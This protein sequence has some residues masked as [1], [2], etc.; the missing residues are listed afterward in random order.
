MISL[1][2]TSHPLLEFTNTKG[3]ASTLPSPAHTAGLAS[4][5]RLSRAIDDIDLR[6]TAPRAQTAG[7]LNGGYTA[8]Y[9]AKGTELKKIWQ[10][11]L[12][13]CHRSDPE[14]CG[15]VS[16]NVFIAALEKSDLERAMTPEAM[17]KL[18]DT[19]TLSNGLVNYL[20]LFRSYLNDISGTPQSLSKSQSALTLFKSTDLAKSNELKPIHP[21]H[22]W[23]YG[24]ERTKHP[25]H[26]YWQQAN[27]MPRLETVKPP[28]STATIPPPN[29]KGAH[30]LT[31]SEKEAL[32]SQFHPKV[33]DLC[34][35]CYKLLA[36]IWR[37]L[38]NQFKKDQIASQRGSI[39]TPHFLSILETNGIMLTKGELATIVR[40]FRGLGMQDVVKYDEFLRVCMLVKDRVM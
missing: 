14:R 9:N 38:R 6:N 18:A 31:V 15:Q 29:E 32:L 36:P 3:L 16:R 35:R 21:V 12:R 24:Y 37:P 17:S 13:E 10:S 1:I 2:F 34:H 8:K 26:P 25:A 4:S 11:V 7:A 39:L 23:D 27:Q 33:L 19:Y 22:P 20:H 5:L 40:V 28:K 30:D